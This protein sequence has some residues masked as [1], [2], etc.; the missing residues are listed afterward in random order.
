MNPKDIIIEWLKQNNGRGFVNDEDG[1]SC[2]LTDGEE[3][4]ACCHEMYLCEAKTDEK[5]DV[6]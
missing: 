6:S 2:Q 4:M 5:D 3:F 1:C